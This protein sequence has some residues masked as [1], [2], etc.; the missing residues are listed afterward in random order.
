M[1]EYRKIHL[2]LPPQTDFSAG[3]AI[4]ARRA[5]LTVGYSAD[6][7]GHGPQERAVIVVNP[8]EWEGG[9]AAL[10]QFFDTYYPGTIL[11]FISATTTGEFVVHALDALGQ[12]TQSIAVSMRDRRWA[13]HPLGEV[14]DTTIGNAGCLL[15]CLTMAI[16]DEYGV[17]IWP[18]EVDD[19]LVAERV[20]Y[21]G[22]DL[23][24]WEVAGKLF[25]FASHLKINTQFTAARI[26]NLLKNE[27]RVSVVRTSPYHAWYV[28]DA[29]GSNLRVIDPLTG[30]QEIYP[31]SRFN[32]IRALN[33]RPDAV[34][35]PPSTSSQPQPQPQPRR[36]GELISVF[37]LTEWPDELDRFLAEVQ[38]A[39]V[40]LLD[41][42]MAPRVRSVCDAMIIG[43]AYRD[44]Y[45]QR[46]LLTSSTGPEEFLGS[47]L[48]DARRW[49]ITVIE[50][51]N[52]TCASGDPESIRA[53]V[54]FESRL[55][56]LAYENGLKVV[57][58]NAP[59][60]NI[61]R[62][63]AVE[64]FPQL[65]SALI[66]TEGYLGVHSYWGV[67]S[68][69]RSRLVSGWDADAG[70]FGMWLQAVPDLRRVPIV[71]TECGAVGIN[72]D[73]SAFIPTAGWRDLYPLPRYIEDLLVFR[74]LI[75]K[76]PNVVG[77]TIFCVGDGQWHS[78]A[79]L[80]DELRALRAA[81][82]KA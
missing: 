56:R 73:A 19:L 51:L 1:R 12:T 9:E 53:A 16:R 38:P 62:E 2:L 70:R 22:A 26:A 40:K 42:S 29:T 64:F 78:F 61:S 69:G 21:I 65:V 5:R 43:R 32:G 55:A 63:E 48:P 4:V 59:V 79:L 15:C 17:D 7:A 82:S 58:L 76:Y 3:A 34:Q 8:H 80:N 44:D 35:T 60:R 47:I 18:S 50:G 37:V 41:W 39:C 20:P 30:S 67:T 49:G 81:L 10:T 36:T 71:I 68:D 23:V 45:T 6:D 25:G 31:A 52:E 66:E 11:Q 46:R 33:R 74:S 75:S 54:R 13:N 14:T 72:V 24:N 27:W 28:L 77:A 57:A